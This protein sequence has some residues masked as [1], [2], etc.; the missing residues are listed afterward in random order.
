MPSAGLSVSSFH[1][2][3]IEINKF[4]EITQTEIQRKK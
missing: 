2:A 3:E 1:M 4:K